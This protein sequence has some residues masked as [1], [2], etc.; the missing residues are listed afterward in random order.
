MAVAIVVNDIQDQGDRI[1]VIGTLVFSGNYTAGAGN[2]ETMNF[3]LATTAK[4]AA[5]FAGIPSS[6]VPISVTAT[7][8]TSGICPSYIPN[9][10]PTRDNG[11]WRFFTTFNT[12]LA[13]APTAYPAAITGDTF[14][15]QACFRKL[16]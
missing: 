5:S 1:W 9:A 12:E 10:N 14:D 3:G 2:G 8:R 6:D 7:G 13:G 4:L 11:K 16:I 15:F